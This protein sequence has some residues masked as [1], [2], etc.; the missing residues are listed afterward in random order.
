MRFGVLGTGHW[1]RTVHAAALRAHPTA[2][3]VAVWGRDAAR[4]DAAGAEFDVPGSTDLADLLDRVD[5]VSIAVPPD[6]QVPL[7][8]QAAEAGRHLL[9]EKPVA[10]TVADADRVA[11]AVRLA[12]VGSVVFFAARF[13]A[14]TSTWLAQAART[15]L[16]G[17]AV[18]WLGSVAGT[19]FGDSAWRLEHGALWDLGP[20]ALSLLV[21]A[22][23]PV[24]SV[25]AGGGLGDT[26]HLVLRHEGGAAS[27]V[28]LSLTAAP[29]S[30]GSEVWLHGEGG[31]LVL[32][33]EG[34]DSAVGAHQVA[35]DELS[36]AALT[37]GVHPCDVGV[38]RE[39][40]AVLAAAQRALAS[41]CR[42]PVR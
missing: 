36:A 21:P 39:V 7:A 32:L 11:D 17:G 12:G 34:D 4:A 19:P 35:V 42:E 9:L 3:L 1:A 38:G 24:T 16:A 10:L 30:G 15:P 27:T 20:H 6:V 37:G 14:A 31:R 22:L 23:G 25:Q 29:L 40:T 26:V 28:T 33:P 13:H 2:E 18:S 8:V 5:A 41:G